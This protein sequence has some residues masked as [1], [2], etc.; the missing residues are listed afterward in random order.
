VI[1]GAGD[2]PAWRKAATATIRTARGT[3]FDGG[4]TVVQVMAVHDGEHVYFLFRWADPQRSQKHLPLVK[5][6]GGWKVMQSAYE[7]DD[8]NDYYEDKF[9]VVL[10]RS[11]ALGSGT[12][13][14]GQ[15]LVDGPHRPVNRGLH[16]TEDG[17][18]ADMW[19]WKSVRTGGMSPSM[20][21]D[22]FFGPPMP[23]EQAGVRY[24]GG[25][26]KDPKEGGDYIL[27]WDKIDP[28]KPLNETLVLPKFLPSSNVMLSRMGEPTL[29][30]T[31]G[32]EGTW[33]LRRDEVV[34]Y[35]PALDDYP[36]GTV[37][38]GV[39]ID[40]AFT[41]DRGDLLGGA[42]WRDGYWTLE[43]SRLL[44]TGSPYDLALVRD[45]PAYLWVA[46]F[47]HS[48]TRHSQHLH[49]VRVNLE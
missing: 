22:N 40:G 18:L 43:I 36:L 26:S 8:E 41:G 33:Y 23:S 17:S 2:D 14:L 31:V 27:N 42:Q 24:T 15:N 28:S 3:N 25:Y 20:V 44:D 29:D 10:A 34:A 12:A 1:D 48:Q 21:D 6:E 49:P 7:I 46:A 37:L 38:P 16:F 9:S 13:H 5:V 45:Q 30:P 39:V 19:H 32:D 35:D 47:N 11:P 4:E